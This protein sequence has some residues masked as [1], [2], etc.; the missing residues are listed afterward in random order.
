MASPIAHSF[1]GFWTFPVFAKQFQIRLAAQCRQYLPRLGV[2]V[3]LANLPDFDFLLSLGLFENA[4]LHHEFAHSLV[5]AVLVALAVS[6]VWRIVPGFWRSA[7][8]Y[9]TAYGSH[10]L[11]DLCKGRTLGWTN[12]DAGIPLLWPWPKKISARPWY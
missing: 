5:A 7:M 9:F 11:I 4:S 10:L 8:I 3:L 6:C 12:T 1:A 2:L